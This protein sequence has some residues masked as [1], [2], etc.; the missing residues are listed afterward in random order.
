MKPLQIK[1]HSPASNI[2]AETLLAGLDE[3]LLLFLLVQRELHVCRPGAIAIGAIVQD[4]PLVVTVG[5]A[6]RFRRVRP[7]KPC[8]PS[9]PSA[10][11]CTTCGAPACRQMCTLPAG[12]RWHSLSPVQL[13]VLSQLVNVPVGAISTVVAL[14]L[15][16]TLL[17]PSIVTET[18][19]VV[20]LAA[21]LQLSN[22]IAC[23][24]Y[25][26]QLDHRSG[27]VTARTG[28]GWGI[29]RPTRAWADIRRQR[30]AGQR[31][32]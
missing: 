16:V 4:A 13:K 20:P 10:R 12:T 30:V 25:G 9:S 5:Q 1:C 7:N 27:C 8:H 14:K 3:H 17:F 29:H 21:P 28:L 31:S 32:R 15:A 2:L 24:R 23:V 22:R 19:L 18:G 11:W 26:G 6:S